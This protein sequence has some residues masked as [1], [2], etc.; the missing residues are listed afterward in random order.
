MGM[1][2]N[3]EVAAARQTYSDAASNFETRITQRQAAKMGLADA[4]S[5]LDQ[6]D[7]L[8]DLAEIATHEAFL[9][10]RDAIEKAGR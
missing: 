5:R 4:Q 8:Y 1:D 3:P 6:A 9:I 2:E 10:L 7:K